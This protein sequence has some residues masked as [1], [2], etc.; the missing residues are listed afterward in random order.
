MAECLV[1][2]GGRSLIALRRSKSEEE[3][4]SNRERLV[5]PDGSVRD[6]VS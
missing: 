3:N 2:G 4:E 6:T 5:S 1:T